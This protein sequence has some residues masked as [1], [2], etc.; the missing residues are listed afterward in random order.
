MN[1]SFESASLDAIRWERRE[2]KKA[3]ALYWAGKDTGLTDKEYDEM[4]EDTGHICQPPATLKGWA[5][6][7][8]YCLAVP[9]FGLKKV[10]YEIARQA[11]KWWLKWDGI[12]IQVFKDKKGFHFVTRGDGRIGKDL[13]CL[14]KCDA[15]FTEPHNFELLYRV[16]DG[17]RAKLCADIS[18]GAFS[19]VWILKN[20]ELSNQH[21]GEPLPELIKASIED[22]PCDGYVIE[23]ASGEKFKYKG[24]GVLLV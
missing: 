4:A 17:G 3:D 12:F 20:H 5:K 11:V 9:N 22:L 13:K 19:K 8:D 14:F 7:P 15:T 10:S 23:L 21:K 24:Q 1:M 2:L 6:Y 18:Q 16:I